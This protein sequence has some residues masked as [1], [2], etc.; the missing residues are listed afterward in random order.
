MAETRPVDPFDIDFSTVDA[1]RRP[2]YRR[3]SVLNGLLIGLALGL[4]AWGMEMARIARLPVSSYLPALLLGLGLVVALCGLVGWLTGRIG[5]T[6][7]TVVLWGLAAVVCM[8]ILG[9]L[10]YYGR[11][12]TVWLLDRQFWGRAIFPYAL[13]GSPIGVVLGGLLIILVLVGLALLQNY[14]LENISLEAGPRGRLNARGWLSLLIPLPV[15]FLASLITQS[16]LSNPAA[17]AFEI[18]NRAVANAQAYDGDLRGLELGDGISYGALQPVKALLGPAYTLSIVD[19][20]PLNSTVIVGV[21]FADGGWVYCRVINDQLSFC[22]DAS[23]PYIEGLRSLVTGVPP[24]E[25]CRG[26]LLQATDE[27]AAWLAERRDA[28][29]DPEIHRVAQQGNHVLMRVRGDAGLTVE[30]W[31]VGVTPMRL[32]ECH[33]VE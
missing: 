9:Y 11:T 6:P 28:I 5:L 30:C 16:V 13:E 25:D 1:H 27:A 26:C 18:T 2:I 33:E 32:T 20:N 15:V 22:Y 14:R 4:G 8:L 23:P 24:A 21:D 3:L 17:A 31:V 19:I 7:V 10:P 12:L 29:G